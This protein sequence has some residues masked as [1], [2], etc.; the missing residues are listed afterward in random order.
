M[1]LYLQLPICVHYVVLN[2]AQHN[3][4]LNSLMQCEDVLVHFYFLVDK[5]DTQQCEILKFSH[6]CC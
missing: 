3:E 5:E 2:L 4:S 6:Q 1:E